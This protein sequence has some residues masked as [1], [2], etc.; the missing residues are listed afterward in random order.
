MHALAL[1]FGILSILLSLN[2]YFLIFAG[3]FW[4]FGLLVLGISHDK[5]QHLLWKLAAFVLA[6]TTFRLIYIIIRINWHSFS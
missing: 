1:L 3:L 5:R 2:A 4:L 6:I